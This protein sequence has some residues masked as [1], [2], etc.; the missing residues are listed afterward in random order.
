MGAATLAWL[1]AWVVAI[2]ADESQTVRVALTTV[3]LAAVVTGI[4]AV[5][6]LGSVHAATVALAFALAL[7]VHV[8]VASV[9][10]RA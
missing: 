6:G 5:S 1:G 10:R 2:T 8:A 9:M 7:P 3:A 4:L